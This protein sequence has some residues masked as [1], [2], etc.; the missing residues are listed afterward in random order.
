MAESLDMLTILFIADNGKRG[1][2][3]L[4]HKVL[5]GGVIKWYWEA[6]GNEGNENSAWEATYAARTWIRDGIHST[7]A[8]SKHDSSKTTN[9]GE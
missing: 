9:T 8:T 3:K 5:K 2:Y 6:M 7:G 1:T 4:W